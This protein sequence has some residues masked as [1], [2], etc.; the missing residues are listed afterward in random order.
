M[1]GDSGNLAD[2]EFYTA[3]RG[4]VS[5]RY[6]LRPDNAKLETIH[7]THASTHW[8]RKYIISLKCI[9]S[10]SVILNYMVIEYH[11]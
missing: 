3:H 6:S 5:N 2:K 8:E 11:L 10:L 7:S 9:K 1:D 4:I